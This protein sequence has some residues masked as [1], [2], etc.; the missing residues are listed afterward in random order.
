LY[1]FALGAKINLLQIYELDLNIKNILKFKRIKGGNS[2]IKPVKM[3]KIYLAI[4][5]R[6]ETE[7]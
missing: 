1:I 3:K 6:Y 2:V 4:P 7:S 5:R